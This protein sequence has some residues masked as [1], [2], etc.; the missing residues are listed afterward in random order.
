MQPRNPVFYLTIPFNRTQPPDVSLVNL[1]KF[2][3]SQN[4]IRI[5]M[6]KYCL[7]WLL[8][9]FAGF[10]TAQEEL[11][12]KDVTHLVES[13]RRHHRSLLTFRSNPLTQDYDLKYHRLEW[14]VD[15][16]VRYISGEVTSYFVPKT[17]GFNR[18]HFDLQD[19]MIVRSV[20]YRGIPVSFRKTGDD[21]LQIDLPKVL[22]TGVLDSITVAYEGAP[23][24]DGFG[25]FAT[26][27]HKGTPVL[28][29]LSEP[30]GARNWW[31]C[32]Q[33]LSDKIDSIDVIVT[34]PQ[35]YRVG[36]NGVL[37]KEFS[38]GN[39]RTTYHWRHR[40]PIPAY[41][42]SLAVTNYEVFTDYVD[43]GNG[44]SIPIVN[45][46]YPESL[47]A[48][49]IQ[50]RSTIEQMDLF[51]R[52]FGLYPFA[53]EKYGHA[54]F[55]WGGGMEHQT[56]SSMGGFSY[57]LQAHELAHQWFG[58]K[59]TCA[60]W[61]DI[62]LNEGFATYLTG[63]TGE[64]LFSNG[65]AW[66][67]WKTSTIKDVTSQPS[68]SVWVDDTTS[69]SRIF[70][71]RLSYQKGAML[72]HMLRWILGDD[73]FFRATRNYLNDPT[74][75]YGYASTSDLQRHLEAEGNIDLDE[76]FDDWLYGEGYPSYTLKYAPRPGGVLISVEQRSSHP[77]VDFFEMPVPVRV[78]GEGQS[79]TLVLDHR[80]SG[81]LFDLD[82][83]FTPDSLTF[84]PE[85]WILSRD[86]M[87]SREEL[88]SVDGVGA[89][90]ASI[91][92]FPNPVRDLLEVRVEE[93]R[94]V[95]EIESVIVLDTQGRTVARIEV[96][97]ERMQV[98]LSDWPAGVY[99]VTVHTAK[100]QFARRVVKVAE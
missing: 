18:L 24:S 49:Q 86:N 74:L 2:M 22:L 5:R 12:C 54:Q 67:N 99:V 10:I 66:E 25:S 30:Y 41:L 8:L 15:P 88:S 73:A 51:N 82:L 47:G 92:L 33:D 76:F 13:E 87:V 62:W 39:G 36:T 83:S 59:V 37:V 35:A 98:D 78:F 53:A 80:Y 6:K 45:Y 40:Y 71:Y 23:V 85:Q 61:A 42:I 7:L 60:S 21:V 52:L 32:K 57:G 97:S 9:G 55:G 11:I 77:R 81:Q 16:A 4:T 79:T 93:A 31:P 58:N 70:N 69:V 68:G 96:I 94:F 26:G 56:M 44:A 95:D 38:A 20:R 29:T 46:V 34:T 43:L 91:R 100:G 28:W 14:E 89:I 64:F 75:A 90:Q 63:L 50:L 65:S 48:A 19:S 84:D 27:T 17:G 1:T 72:L 3:L